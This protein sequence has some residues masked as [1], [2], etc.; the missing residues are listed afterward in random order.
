MKVGKIKLL[1]DL[2]SIWSHEEEANRVKAFILSRFLSFPSFKF[3]LYFLLFPDE[4]KIRKVFL[5]QV[6]SSV[7]HT[8][9]K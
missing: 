6:I 1:T 4:N 8:K 2:L 7:W 9:K 5:K 3:A